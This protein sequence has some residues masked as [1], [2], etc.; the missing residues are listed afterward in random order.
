VSRQPIPTWYFAL[1]V[2]RR[3]D[4]FLL[5]QE[6]RHGQLWYLPAG[7]A[8][9]GEDLVSTAR[10]ETLEEAGIP[11][12]VEGILRVEHSPDPG[13]NARLRVVFAARP[14]DDTAPKSVPDAE[15]LRAVWAGLDELS[16]YPLRGDEVLAMCEYAAR[17][18]PV[19]PLSL[20][21]REGAPYCV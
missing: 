4:Q 17:G 18:G 6:C 13:G 9:P 16:Y 12:V 14:A 5:V 10:R 21:Q 3:E 15:S 1:V 2:V 8:E 19:Y 7:R 11:I 20:L